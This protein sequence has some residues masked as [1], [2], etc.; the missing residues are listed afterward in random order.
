MTTFTYVAT[1]VDGAAVKGEREAP[2]EER[3]RYELLALNLAVE[4][5]KEK[6]PLLQVEIAPQRVKPT[7][8]MHFSRQIAAFVRAGISI[9][10]ALEVVRDGS[11]NK[12]W[13]QIVAEMRENIEAGVPFAET[14]AQHAGLFPPYYLGIVR[15]AELTGRLDES[16]DQLADYMTRDLDARHQIKSALTYPI[17]IALMSVV[18]VVIMATF[19]LPRFVKFFQ[20]LHSKL[21]LPTRILLGVADFFKTFWFVT[22]AVFLAGGAFVLWM[23]RSE[24]GRTLRDRMLFSLPAIRGVVQYAVIERFSRILG[25][26]VGGGVSLPEAMAGAVA[27]ANNRLFAAKLRDAQERM[28]EGEGLAGPVEQAG[29]FPTAAVQMM[30]VGENTGTLEVQLA[31]VSQYYG[32]E[33]EFRLK[34][35]TSLFEPAVII[36]MGVI[37]GFVAVAL[38][39]A[40]YGVLN[41]QKVH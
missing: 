7:E 24:S 31:N 4:K 8:I 25:A 9:T 27:A 14:I 18:T 39:S 41:G 23:R 1:D 3:L 30:R 29:V 37:V 13:R 34:K 6:K 19:V 5:I 40:M 15:S 28:L 11:D 2:S 26:M 22:P 10:D 16:L 21:P 20:Q 12:R 32:R 17:V 33:L 36:F 38:I 35:L